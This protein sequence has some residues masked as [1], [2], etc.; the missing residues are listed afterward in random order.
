MVRKTV[1][2]LDTWYDKAME[3]RLACERD[4]DLITC[5][6]LDV[7]AATAALGQA[8]VYQIC[9]TRDEVPE[10]L[11]VTGSL[12]GRCPNLLCVSTSGAGFDTVDVAAC[13]AAGIL[14]VN[15]AGGNAAAVAEHTIA[16][17]LAL[18]R[19]ILE[20]D[21]RLRRERGFTRE[22]LMGSDVAGKTIGLV[23]LGHVGTCV[24]ALAQAF[25]MRVV[26]CDPYLTP[27]E[28]SRRGASALSL[29]GVL[30]QADFVS[31]HC[32]RNKETLG[33]IGQAEFGRMR[34][35]AF[36]LTTARGGI[37]DE[38][39]LAEALARG[40][41]AG[42]AVDVWDREPPPLDHPLL[43]SDKVIATYHT[44]GVTHEA[45]RN[46]AAIAAEQIVTV[47]RGERPPRL[48]N[49][50]AFPAFLR[51]FEETIIAEACEQ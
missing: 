29:E 2:R 10:G 51:R 5:E 37:H 40:H 21:R 20:S 36:F 15:Q 1:V 32:P 19:R 7:A 24:A 47:L 4:I 39:A 45:R 9:S 27:D 34:K 16:M 14:V 25:G 6:R 41:L 12:V 35:G 49:V 13:T 44:A 50:A 46:M 33:M 30:A 17:V 38:A 31:L 11:F 8:H 26:A 28:I 3:E 48:V 42:A 43:A 22:D 18:S 23:G